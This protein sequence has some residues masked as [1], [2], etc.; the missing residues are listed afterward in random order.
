MSVFETERGLIMPYNK[1]IDLQKYIVK[2]T[3]PMFKYEKVIR[4]KLFKI[5]TDKRY[6][7]FAK[8]SKILEELQ[9]ECLDKKSQ[10]PPVHGCRGMRFQHSLLQHQV[11][12]FN[13]IISIL[14]DTGT[15][16]FKSD[17]GSGK[18]YILG[19][20]MEHF[21][22]PTIVVGPGK[23]CKKTWVDMAP[24]INYVT[25]QY[26][27]KN[28][29]IFKTAGL[30]I[31]DEVHNICTLA[32]Y[33]L[34]WWCNTKYVIGCSATPNKLNGMDKFIPYFLGPLYD[35]NNLTIH[36]SGY[37]HAI[38]YTSKNEC[39]STNIHEAYRLLESDEDRNELLTHII[40]NT[41]KNMFVFAEHINYLK[42]LDSLITNDSCNKIVYT[43]ES[44]FSDV[45][46]MLSTSVPNIVFTTY[47]MASE[48]L[49]LKN[50]FTIVFA[51]PRKNN[52]TQIVGRILRNSFIHE[53][54]HI[55]D[56]IDYSIPF[57]IRQFGVRSQY[58]RSKNFKISKM[59]YNI[60]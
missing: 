27:L 7:L 25:I 19:K 58:Y 22:L 33:E 18:T 50:F 37:V 28:P 23:N 53:T 20:V 48:S 5:S 52:M 17:V 51:T 10:H 9:Q 8:Y 16:Y 42:Y 55:Y 32:R 12:V 29:N 47:S 21:K 2:H 3:V 38:R 13:D 4:F 56:F 1:S 45:A 31:I 44:K 41:K 35:L 36:Y 46:S 34:L 14:E 30:T 26:A 40:R 60:K 15:C 59:K 39:W 54:R 24:N 49:S 11:K 6:M 57:F 43:G